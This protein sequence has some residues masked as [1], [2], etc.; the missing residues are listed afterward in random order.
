MD[1]EYEATFLDVDKNDIRKKLKDVGA[2]LIKPEYLQKRVVF[3]LPKGL[4]KEN[5]WLRVRKEK[6]TI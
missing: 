5:T 1:I 6:Q 4:E 2:K 3:N